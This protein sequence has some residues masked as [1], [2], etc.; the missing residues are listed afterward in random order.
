MGYGFGSLYAV[1]HLRTYEEALKRFEKTK[2]IRGTD[3][4]VYPL[5]ERRNKHLHIRK[6]GNGDVQCILYRT[7]VVTFKPDNT[8]TINAGQ[9]TSHFTCAFIEAVL[10]GVQG[11]HVRRNMVLEVNGTEYPLGKDQTLTLAAAHGGG[12]EVTQAQGVW[13]WRIGR[14]EAN[15]VRAPITQFLKFYK[16]F[17]SLNTQHVGDFYQDEV[18]NDPFVT[19]RLFTLS[20]DLFKQVLGTVTVG[21]VVNKFNP[22][23]KEMEQHPVEVE[24]LDT[25][26]WGCVGN[27][28]VWNTGMTQRR[29]TW[30]EQ[31]DYLYSLMSSTEAADHLKAALIM[32]AAHNQLESAHM[33]MAGY[34][35]RASD[36]TNVIM[37]FSKAANLATEF[38]NKMFAEQ[39]LQYV[40][41]AVGVVPRTSYHGWQFTD[42]AKAK[43]AAAGCT[44]A[45]NGMDL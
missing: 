15:S 10:P 26:T 29:V 19:K 40:Q 3:P 36:L 24:A 1:P 9:Y 32:L 22:Q 38:V 28:P 20:L 17:V 31:R 7:P 13:A 2:P 6:L 45:G 33:H 44:E 41:L 34:G 18:D 5:A 4:A 8:V 11:R 16:G 27:K 37:P 23:T 25:T 30:M 35:R 39:V 42:T 21:R 12:W 14:A 43:I